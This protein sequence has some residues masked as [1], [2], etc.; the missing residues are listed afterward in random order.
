[1]TAARVV[2]IVIIGALVMFRVLRRARPQQVRPRRIA[3][4]TAIIGVVLL[5]AIASSAP[6]LV[7][8]PLGLALAP[9]ALAAGCGIGWLLVKAVRFY[10]HPETGELWMRG[11]AVFI[12]VILATVLLRIGVQYAAGG[13]ATAGTTSLTHPTPLR[14]I[15]S[16]LIFLSAGMW[17]TRGA[18]LLVHHRRHQAGQQSKVDAPE[19][20]R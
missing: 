13:P 8:S 11:D 14:V 19:S 3:I 10:P 17:L 18:L 6:I 7:S 12:A 4:G 20:Q 2:P 1:M 5:L 15:S 9:V 16:D